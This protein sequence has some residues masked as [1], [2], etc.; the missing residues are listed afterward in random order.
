[1]TAELGRQ[2]WLVYGLMRTEDGYSKLVSAGNG[3]FTLLGFMGIY[4]VLGIL[5]LFL[6][7]REIE[8][9]PGNESLSNLHP[10]TEVR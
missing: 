2:P 6:I 3:M 7:W 8:Q 10:A 4:T 9:G 1:M 5:G